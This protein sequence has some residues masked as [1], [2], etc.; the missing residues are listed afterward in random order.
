MDL[1]LFD[2]LL[3][4]SSIHVYAYA[5]E[6][7][8]HAKMHVPLSTLKTKEKYPFCR[9]GLVIACTPSRFSGQ[10]VCNACNFVRSTQLA[11]MEQ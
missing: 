5:Y 1:H 10:L 9:T 11:A 3:S 2:F 4:S 6:I 8:K 7:K